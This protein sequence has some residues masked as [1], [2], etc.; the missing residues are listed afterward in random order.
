MSRAIYTYEFT[1]KKKKKLTIKNI[2]KC[3][4]LFLKKHDRHLIRNRLEFTYLLYRF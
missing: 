3:V 4:Y 1:T 2:R